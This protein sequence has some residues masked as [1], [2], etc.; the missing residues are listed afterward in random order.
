MTSRKIRSLQGNVPRH[1]GWIEPWIGGSVA[2]ATALT[3]LIGDGQAPMLWLFAA[4][5]AL[6]A[7]W[8]WRRPARRQTELAVRAALLMVLGFLTLIQI[9]THQERAANVNWVVVPLILYAILLK[10][11][12]VWGLLGF[13]LGFYLLM[14]Y[15]FHPVATPEFLFLRAGF[16]FIFSAAATHMGEVMRRTDELLEERRVDTSS[17]LLNEYGFMDHGAELWRHC[18]QKRVPATLVFLDVPDLLKIREVYHAG[19][20]G[21]VEAIVLQAVDALD[22]GKH[23]LARLGMWRFALL[24]SGTTR[25][26]AVKLVEGR[27][28][29]PPVI[30]IDEGPMNVTF[31]VDV[32]AVESRRQDMAFADFYKTEL[33][34]LDAQA[35]RVRAVGSKPAA[36]ATFTAGRPAGKTSE[37]ADVP[38]PVTIPMDF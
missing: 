5:A 7:W 31:L 21:M 37:R 33:A 3:A 15:W 29:Q 17:G 38:L 30:K 16:V 27:L 6:L 13:C 19:A 12:F 24:M 11:R 32:H 22:V 26:Q 20:T 25:E 14:L 8:S 23:V 36:S 28:G 35:G 1:I 18:H 4:L 2:C 34:V 10:P 9:E